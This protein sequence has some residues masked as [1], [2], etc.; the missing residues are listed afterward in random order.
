[1][2]EHGLIFALVDSWKRQNTI[3]HLLNVILIFVSLGT[4]VVL[5]L[6]EGVVHYYNLNKGKYPPYDEQHDDAFW[7]PLL[8]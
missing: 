1:M 8:M 4:Y 2:S 6:L 3:R 5:L 7:S